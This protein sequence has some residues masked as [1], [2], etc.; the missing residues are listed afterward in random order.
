MDYLPGYA[1]NPA[2]SVRGTHTVLIGVAAALLAFAISPNDSD[3]Y[4]RAKAELDVVRSLPFAQFPD[5]V[6]PDEERSSSREALIDT[7]KGSGV[8]YKIEPQ[9]I[10]RQPLYISGLPDNSATLHEIREFF[11]HNSMI[12]L[13][14]SQTNEGYALSG[15]VQRGNF[16][17]ESDAREVPCKRIPSGYSLVEVRIT[18]S[19]GAHPLYSTG[20]GVEC[21]RRMPQSFEGT[22]EFKFSAVSYDAVPDMIKA[23][24]PINLALLLVGNQNENTDRLWLRTLPKPYSSL[25]GGDTHLSLFPALSVVWDEVSHDTPDE[26][27]IFLDEKISKS[28]RTISMLGMSIDERTAAVAGTWALLL[29]S[30]YLLAEVR[31]LNLLFSRYPVRDL[32]LLVWP[33]LSLDWLSLLATLVS[34]CLLPI[35]AS[36]SLIW[37]VGHL[38]DYRSALAAVA[39]AGTLTCG[40][41]SVRCLRSIGVT[42][43]R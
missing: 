39:S 12:T 25:I 6:N 19:D 8:P 42:L 18:R 9:L 43:Q 1:S 29:L 21:W 40:I 41:F 23:S 31:N 26:A 10:Y 7:L 13:V 34:I 11:Q 33:C 14:E 5:F 22:I 27:A 15:A 35:A 4:A 36:I 3:R 38:A 30:A 17:C 28:Q 37:R 16:T 24:A 20:K 32:A 2:K